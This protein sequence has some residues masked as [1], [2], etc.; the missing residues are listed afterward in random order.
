MVDIINSLYSFSVCCMDR[1]NSKSSAGGWRTK[2]FKSYAEGQGGH[3]PNP[4]LPS[5]HL[6]NEWQVGSKLLLCL[7]MDPL[8]AVERFHTTTWHSVLCSVRLSESA[9]GGGEAVDSL[10]WVKMYSHISMYS[11]V[12]YTLLPPKLP[13]VWL[14][15]MIESAH[16]DLL[17]SAAHWRPVCGSHFT[18]Q[19]TLSCF[20]ALTQL[21]QWAFFCL[22]FSYSVNNGNNKMGVAAYEKV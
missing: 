15:H 19:T 10:S 21:L 9:Q 7:S 14:L 4:K 16:K 22:L 1:L 13:A 18:P 12:F 3:Q 2:K 5:T 6:S 17:T 20:Q 11:V 8:L